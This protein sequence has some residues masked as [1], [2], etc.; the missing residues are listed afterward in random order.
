MILLFK[1]PPGTGLK[2]LLS[3]VPQCEKAVT[4]LTGKTRVLDKLGS[5]MSSS[6]DGH[7][8]NVNE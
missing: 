2:C 6:T 5:G 7:E 4:R 1:G 8:F 3:S